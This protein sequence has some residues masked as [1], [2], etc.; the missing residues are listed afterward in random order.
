M[1]EYKQPINVPNADIYLTQDPNKLKAQ[2]LNKGTG[3]QQPT[4]KTRTEKETT[5]T[6]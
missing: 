4:N 5:T 3:V 2:D 1:A 6:N